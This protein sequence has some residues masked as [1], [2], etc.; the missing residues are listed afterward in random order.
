MVNARSKDILHG[1]GEGATNIGE[2]EVCNTGVANHNEFSQPRNRNVRVRYPTIEG[3]KTPDTADD[4]G[5]THI[6][7]TSTFK[8]L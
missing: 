3:N 5:T 8:S 1:E 4:R 6:Q 7:N 2:T